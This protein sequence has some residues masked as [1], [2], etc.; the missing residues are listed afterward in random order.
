MHTLVPME[1]S[2]TTTESARASRLRRAVIM[3]TTIFAPNWKATRELA[4]LAAERAV[5][6]SQDGLLR[7]YNVSFNRQL[8][9]D[10]ITVNSRVDT[11]LGPLQDIPMDSIHIMVPASPAT[12]A[13]DGLYED[14]GITARV[15]TYIEH[16]V[17]LQSI[18]VSGDSNTSVEAL[19]EWLDDLVAGKKGGYNLRPVTYSQT[20]PPN[21]DGTPALVGL[22]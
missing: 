11:T 18:R 13:G 10:A 8:G 16:G 5:S 4:A 19:S 7:G 20:N 6:T 12:S 3:T 14:E 22:D 1:L 2:G 17:W 15:E 21:D 9:C